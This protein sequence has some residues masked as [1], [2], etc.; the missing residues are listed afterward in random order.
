MRLSICLVLLSACTRSANIYDD[1]DAGFTPDPIPDAGDIPELDAGLDSDAYPACADR[2]EAPGCVGPVDF[3]CNFDSWVTATAE[4]CQMETSCQTNGWLEV[5]MGRDGCVSTIG[6]TE[7][8]DPMVT[9]L[10]AEFADAKCPCS[11][12]SSQYFFGLENSGSCR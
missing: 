8:N 2:P 1:P 7:P 5:T 11:G 9:C 12:G 4:R 3:P 10:L 6:L